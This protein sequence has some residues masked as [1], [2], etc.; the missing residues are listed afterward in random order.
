MCFERLAGRAA[1]AGGGI[2]AGLLLWLA[3][4][5]LSVYLTADDMVNIYGAWRTPYSRILLEIICYFTPGYRPLGSLVYRLL[6]DA[7]GLDPLPFRVVCFA[8]LLCNLVLF[9]RTA[10][11]IA[12][13]EVALLGMLCASY[14]AGFVDLYYNTG[15]IYDLLCYT[16]YFLALN[17]YVRVRKHGRY[18]SIR[19]WAMFLSFYIWA[20]DSKEMAVTLPVI[21]LCYEL[22]L[23]TTDVVTSSKRRWPRWAPAAVSGLMT[24]PFAIGKLSASSP[25]VGNEAYRLHGGLRTYFE[26]LRHYAE[27]FTLPPGR[28]RLGVLLVSLLLPGIVAALGRRRVLIFA[29]LFCLLTPLPVAFIALRGGY[30]VYIPTFGMAL[31]FAGSIVELRGAFVQA[32]TTRNRSAERSMKLGAFGLCLAALL[33]FHKHR[34]LG[35]IAAEDK[36]LRSVAPQIRSLQPEI[37]PTWRILFID[38]PFPDDYA[39]LFLVRLYYLAPDMTVDRIKMMPR[40]PSAG[41][42]DAYDCIFTFRAI[43]GS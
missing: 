26:A 20:L 40:K 23:G 19:Q 22:V 9:Y 3:R 21:L 13:R 17:L 28:L 43:Q 2:A 18:L 15:T 35:D 37:D 34:P 16:F 27:I 7:A 38:D 39:L 30:A 33:L 29:W 4:P 6:F 11:A 32:V 36:M 24:V 41:E 14:N 8:L 5:G 10:E 42:V 31:F 12:S 1:L 25:L